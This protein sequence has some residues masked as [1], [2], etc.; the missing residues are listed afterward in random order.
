[1]PFAIAD[2]GN[3]PTVRRKGRLL[4][5][6]LAI[7]QRREGCRGECQLLPATGIITL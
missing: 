1:M 7:G 6:R 5:E 3:A 4:I 2:E